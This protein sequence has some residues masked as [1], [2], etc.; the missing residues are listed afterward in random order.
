ML[1][2]IKKRYPI[3]PR[4]FLSCPIASLTIT[5]LQQIA[6]TCKRRPNKHVM[7]G[8]MFHPTHIKLMT[9]SRRGCK[10]GFR[11]S[12]GM[13]E[14]S[15]SACVEVDVCVSMTA[16]DCLWIDKSKRGHSGESWGQTDVFMDPLY[17]HHRSH[18]HRSYTLTPASFSAS[19]FTPVPCT[20]S[21]SPLPSLFLSIST[22]L[23]AHRAACRTSDVC[24]S[25]VKDRI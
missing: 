4:E 6:G 19:A 5:F 20:C 1:L 16:C 15:F 2:E 21:S 18:H 14:L 10:V 17:C 24:R 7:S 9:R 23:W 22:S 13:L 3:F 12:R 11:L 8:D 25:W